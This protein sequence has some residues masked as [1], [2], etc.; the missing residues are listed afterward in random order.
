MGNWRYKATYII[1]TPFIIGSSRGLPCI[2]YRIL[3]L[4]FH[5]PV[6]VLGWKRGFVIGYP[7]IAWD[8]NASGWVMVKITLL[9]DGWMCL[10]IL[11]RKVHLQLICSHNIHW[12]SLQRSFAY[13]LDELVLAWISCHDHAYVAK[14]L[15]ESLN[16]LPLETVKA[17][18]WVAVCVSGRFSISC[19]RNNFHLGRIGPLERRASRTRASS[20]YSRL[21]FHDVTLKMG[22]C[23]QHLT[24]SVLFSCFMYL[25]PYVSL[26]L[27]FFWCW[28]CVWPKCFGMFWVVPF[29]YH[30][31]GWQ[32]TLIHFLKLR[33]TSQIAEMSLPG[34]LG[35]LAVLVSGLMNHQVS[36]QFDW[37]SGY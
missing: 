22:P 30:E 37:G 36:F 33:S 8:L 16:V 24:T 25:L 26:L 7:S 17:S 10:L 4:L 34:V 20:A 19:Y 21:A 23:T 15:R 5:P 3:I 11:N 29:W 27:H 1:D 9:M 31:K 28:C 14:I 2:I 18:W 13:G 12:Y 32:Q 35:A 6:E